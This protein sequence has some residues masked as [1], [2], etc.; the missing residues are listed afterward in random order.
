MLRS[1]ITVLF[2]IHENAYGHN[3][4]RNFKDLGRTQTMGFECRKICPYALT[5][6]SIRYYFS[7]SANSLYTGWLVAGVAMLSN[8]WLFKNE[9]DEKWL[10]Q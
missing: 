9:A 6:L 1:F 7:V 2:K 3:F 4:T 8:G 10:C 5:Y